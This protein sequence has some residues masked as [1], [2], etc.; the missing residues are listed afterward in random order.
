MLAYNSPIPLLDCL[1][2]ILDYPGWFFLKAAFSSPAGNFSAFVDTVKKT[3][4]TY[5]NGAFMT[6]SFLENHDQPRFQS[7]TQD[8]AVGPSPAVSISLLKWNANQLVK[9][10]VAF[11]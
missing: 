6:G 9:N 7:V 1:D 5:K 10:D 8:Q 3:Q 2:S 4:T 11:H